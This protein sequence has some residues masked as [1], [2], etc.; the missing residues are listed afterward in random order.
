MI[1]VADLVLGS[2]GWHYL[3]KPHTGAVAAALEQ[4]ATDAGHNNWTAVYRELCRDD[5]AQISESDLAGEGHAALLSIGVLR[6]VTVASVRNVS[7]SVGPLDIP[8]AAQASGELIPVLGQ[9]SAFTVTLVR[10]LGGWHV[11]LSAGGYSS[12]A[13]G[14]S[15]PLGGGFTP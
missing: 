1:L 7:Q 9:P 4:T 6:R 15:Q 13:L 11:C 8:N 2:V 12:A 5:Q 3:T 10:E 14:A